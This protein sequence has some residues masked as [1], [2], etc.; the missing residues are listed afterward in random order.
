M[1]LGSHHDLAFKAL[2]NATPDPQQRRLHIWRKLAKA[3]VWC[4]L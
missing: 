3:F 2:T 4:E 1:T